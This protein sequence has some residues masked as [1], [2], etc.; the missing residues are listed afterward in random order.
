VRYRPP[1]MKRSGPPPL[2]AP[3][4]RRQLH[5][6]LRGATAWLLVALLGVA[7]ACDRAVEPYVPGEKP[8]AP[9]L[10]RIFPEGAKRAAEQ[11]G[12]GS[13]PAAGPPGMPGAGAAAASTGSGSEA[14]IQGT[15]TLAPSLEGRVPAGAI[16]FLIARRGAGPGP[17]LAVQR[18]PSPKLPLQFS[19]GPDD[20]MIR[21]MPFAG[22][23]T[24]TARLDADGNA[25][26]HEPGDLEGTAA[27]TYEPGA[28]GVSIV[29]DRAL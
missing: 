25:M 5:R 28:S 26:T 24:L 7:A 29:I 2:L 13:M 15:V 27:G 16:L 14:P 18:I 4:P 9:D 17:P 3:A 20:R 10:A 19:I 21:Q 23:I 11:E 6:P 8:A 12:G 1:A 22:P